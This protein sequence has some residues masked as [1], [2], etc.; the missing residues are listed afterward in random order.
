[1]EQKKSHK[2]YNWA[3]IF[4][5]ATRRVKWYTRFV[6]KY[7]LGRRKSF[8]PHKVYMFLVRITSRVDLDMSVCPSDR[9]NA[10]IS[11]TIKATILGLGMKISETYAQR[12]FVSSGCHTHSYDH[13]PHKTV[14]PTVLMLE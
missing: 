5:P 4:I 9:L 14:A 10:E 2:K 11:E 3:S 7:V 12:M 6:G 8:L 1:M 13:K